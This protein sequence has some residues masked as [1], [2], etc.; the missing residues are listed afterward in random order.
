MKKQLVETHNLAGLTDWMN[1][2]GIR[3]AR[4]Q[5]IRDTLNKE[6]KIELKEG[7]YLEQKVST[8]NFRTIKR[9]KIIEE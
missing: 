4:R 7:W 6:G 3:M 8:E 2:I 1:Q 5:L 9:Y